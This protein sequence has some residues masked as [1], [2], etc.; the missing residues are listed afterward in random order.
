MEYS[1]FT[2]NFLRDLGFI[3]CWW[4]CR[5]R[6]WISRRASVCDP[7]D[8]ISS[9]LLVQIELSDEF[10]ELVC[11][12]DDAFQSEFAQSFRKVDFAFCEFGVVFDDFGAVDWLRFP[13]DGFQVPE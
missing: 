6:W 13:G 4:G 12:D 3:F 7:F 1:R 5:G 2:F 10:S 11:G 8:Q 9:F